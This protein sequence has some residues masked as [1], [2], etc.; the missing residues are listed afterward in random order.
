MIK[1]Y[2]VKIV[3]VWRDVVYIN[4]F[5]ITIITGILLLL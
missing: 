5:M 3:E 4:I 2:I 1:F